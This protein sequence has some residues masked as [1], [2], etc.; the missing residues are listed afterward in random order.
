[1]CT[2]IHAITTWAARGPHDAVLLPTGSQ[3]GAWGWSDREQSC[4]HHCQSVQGMKC[5]S[6]HIGIN[7]RGAGVGC[8]GRSRRGVVAAA[9]QCALQQV[10]RCVRRKHVQLSSFSDINHSSASG[11]QGT[12]L[13]QTSRPMLSGVEG[14][15]ALTILGVISESSIPRVQADKSCERGTRARARRR[16]RGCRSAAAGVCA[17]VS[18]LVLGSTQG[19]HSEGNPR[20]IAIERPPRC[21]NSGMN[22][23]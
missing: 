16:P 12:R 14:S 20:D 22:T 7:G 23:R 15:G 13:P 17:G 11:I 21:F 19:N 2:E 18:G 4:S 9:S 10:K 3:R 1:M 6:N 5:I 8:S